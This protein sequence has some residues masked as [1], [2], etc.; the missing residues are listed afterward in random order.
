MVNPTSRFSERKI[1]YSKADAKK[2]WAT[3]FD[4]QSAFWDMPGWLDEIIL[5]PP[6]REIRTFGGKNPGGPR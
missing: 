1:K 5:Y 2:D 4:E 6:I 3:F